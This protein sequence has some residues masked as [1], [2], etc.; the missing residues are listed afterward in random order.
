[1]ENYFGIYKKYGAKICQRG[2]TRLPQGQVARPLPWSRHLGLWGP[3]GSPP[4][5]LWP[6]IL[7]C[8]RKKK[9]RVS[10]LS[11]AVLR[12]NQGRSTFA[13]RRSDSDTSL[14]EGE[15]E[16]III[17]NAPLIVG[18]IIFINIFTSTI[19]SPNPS[20]SLVFNLCIKPQIGTWGC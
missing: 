16:A 20:S 3:G 5:V 17:T 8:P 18:I 19:S 2:P 14:R 1:M 10:G 12:R 4:D 13:L 9:R 15:I 11:A 6:Y 7:I